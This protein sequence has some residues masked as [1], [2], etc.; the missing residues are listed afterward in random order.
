MKRNIERLTFFVLGAVFVVIGYLIGEFDPK[1]NAQNDIATFDKI[2]CKSLVISSGNPEHGII[3]MHAD[4]NGTRL[5][6]F[7]TGT[8][9][10]KD[11]SRIE[12]DCGNI[13][14]ERFARVILTNSSKTGGRITLGAGES[15][16]AVSVNTADRSQFTGGLSVSAGSTVSLITNESKVVSSVL[17]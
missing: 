6:L 9:D 7:D 16:G 5:V 14:R 12:L 8:G 11:R 10:V 13:T 4:A 17:R 1:V 3:G 15:L 2:A